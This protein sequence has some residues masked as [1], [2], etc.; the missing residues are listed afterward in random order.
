[1]RLSRKQ[2][3]I[4]E[5][6]MR[7]NV[8][9]DGVRESWADVHQ[10]LERLPYKTSRES[11]LCSLKILIDKGLVERGPA[12]LRR[13]RWSVPFVPTDLAFDILRA[14]PEY[15]EIEHDDVIEMICLT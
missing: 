1:M 13:G 11:L 12:E 15:R 3:Q 5:I 7:G 8:R 4:M 6:V 10:L 14:R 9:D 2:R